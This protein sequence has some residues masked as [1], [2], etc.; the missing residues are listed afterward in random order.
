MAKKASE[1]MRDGA[2]KLARTAMNVKARATK[3]RKEHRITELKKT[4]FNFN[5][6]DPNT[7]YISNNLDC[8]YFWMQ[9]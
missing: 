6:L 5:S 7:K 2:D 3:E 1:N 4:K 9:S 8:K